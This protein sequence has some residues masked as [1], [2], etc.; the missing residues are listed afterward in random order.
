MLSCFFR[1]MGMGRGL[2][3]EG[4]SCECGHGEGASDGSWGEENG[5]WRSGWWGGM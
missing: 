3:G 2:G 4:S 5:I 1:W